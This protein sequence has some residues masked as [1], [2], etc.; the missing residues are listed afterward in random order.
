MSLAVLTA[1]PASA[2]SMLHA[3]RFTHYIRPSDPARPNE[4]TDRTVLFYAACTLSIPGKLC[5]DLWTMQE[6]KPTSG[7]TVRNQTNGKID[8]V[9]GGCEIH[10]GSQ[11]IVIDDGADGRRFDPK[12]T[13]AENELARDEMPGPF[14]SMIAPGEVATAA[15][16]QPG[17]TLPV[18]RIKGQLPFRKAA[19]FTCRTATATPAP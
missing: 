1:A 6:S 11:T 2:Q 17:K 3:M 4:A 7:I 14:E 12:A 19:T 5:A 15:F 10:N 18:H 16:F 8:V 13:P 9:L